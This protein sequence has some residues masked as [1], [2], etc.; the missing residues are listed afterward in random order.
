MAQ[1]DRSTQEKDGMRKVKGF[2]DLAKLSVLLM[3]TLTGN[4]HTARSMLARLMD[5]GYVRKICNKIY[6]AVNPSTDSVVVSKYQ[7]ACAINDSTQS[8]RLA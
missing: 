2:R 6:S 1:L 7:I 8:S 4:V 3:E 5:K